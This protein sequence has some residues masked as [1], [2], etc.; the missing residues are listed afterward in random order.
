MRASLVLCD[1]AAQDVLSGKVHL[2]GAGWSMTGPCLPPT[3]LR[4]L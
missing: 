1:Y 3:P 2:M 4:R